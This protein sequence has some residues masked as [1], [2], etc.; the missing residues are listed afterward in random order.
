MAGS[1]YALRRL[2]R[3]AEAR[4]RLDAACA[5]LSQL[6]LYPAEKVRTGPEQERVLW[7]L[8]DHE[9]DT[10]HAARGIELYQGLLDRIEAGGAKPETRLHDAPDRLF[11]ARAAA[12]TVVAMGPQ[13]PQQSFRDPADRGSS[14]ALADLD[15]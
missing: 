1:S 2:G 13:A 4:Q 12:R 9:T 10:G 11:S 7:A 8:A 3:F 5:R 15:D 14:I 6:K